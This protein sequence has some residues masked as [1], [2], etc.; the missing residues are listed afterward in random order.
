MIQ[1]SP[2]LAFTQ[3]SWK[4]TAYAKPAQMCLHSCIHDCQN[5][6]ATRMPVMAK[7][8]VEPP[9]SGRIIRDLGKKK[10]LKSRKDIREALAQGTKWKKTIWKG[11]IL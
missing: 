4:L 10:V 5:L 3:V 6:E 8:M 7:H 11:Y 9:N 2:F 1:Q